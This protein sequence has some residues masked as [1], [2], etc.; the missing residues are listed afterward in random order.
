MDHRPVPVDAVLHVAVGP[1]GDAGL[2]LV[3]DP[4]AEVNQPNEKREQRDDPDSQSRPP[5]AVHAFVLLAG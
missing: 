2:V 1:V 5:V 4:R 3:G